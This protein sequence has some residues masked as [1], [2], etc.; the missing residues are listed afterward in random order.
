SCVLQYQP[1]LLQERK[2]I[3]DDVSSDKKRDRD[4][5]HKPDT[6]KASLP[7]QKNDECLVT[8]GDNLETGCVDLRK[9]P[10]DQ[11][12]DDDHLLKDCKNAS[13]DPPST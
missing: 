2:K 4:G 5:T 7:E 12:M 10:D 6:S 11:D 1:L 13:M 3:L 9:D 8:D